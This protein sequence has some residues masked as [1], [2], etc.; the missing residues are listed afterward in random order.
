VVGG[1]EIW[2]AAASGGDRVAAESGGRRPSVAV[3]SWA[4]AGA[5]IN[6][7][8]VVNCAAPRGEREKK[9]SIRL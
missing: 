9:E 6:F 4:A 2:P 1:D 3:V 8:C 5:A 7:V